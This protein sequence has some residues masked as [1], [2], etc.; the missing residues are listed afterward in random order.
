LGDL[1]R[2]WREDQTT[3]VAPPSEVSRNPRSFQ[4]GEV[5][6]TVEENETSDPW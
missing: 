5:C 4:D 2:T 1:K 6:Q 3:L